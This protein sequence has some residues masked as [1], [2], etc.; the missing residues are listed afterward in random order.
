MCVCVCAWFLY[1]AG[2]LKC[3]LLSC[4]ALRAATAPKPSRCCVT[5]AAPTAQCCCLQ[6]YLQLCPGTKVRLR[7]VMVRLGVL[8]LEP[9][10]IEVRGEGL[11][12]WAHAMF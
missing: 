11:T 6:P 8:L 12:A 7:N 1:L 3:V 10:T 5:I 9:K 2:T 4:A